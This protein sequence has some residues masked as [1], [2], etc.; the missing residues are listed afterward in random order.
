MK[1][2]F[3]NICSVFLFTDFVCSVYTPANAVICHSAGHVPDVRNPQGHITRAFISD[4]ALHIT[5]HEGEYVPLCDTTHQF[6]YTCCV[7][8]FRGMVSHVRPVYN[9][10]SREQKW[11]GGHE[12]CDTCTQK[13]G[14]WDPRIYTTVG[15]KAKK[16][17]SLNHTRVALC[18][19]LQ[20]KKKQILGPMYTVRK[21]HFA[22]G[23]IAT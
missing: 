14:L 6:V 7:Q 15:I 16:V 22:V 8:M 10:Q 12:K 4:I 9:E 5:L 3:A 13:K 1:C 23:V 20:R 21:G 2:W 19:G 18:K 17:W 11:K